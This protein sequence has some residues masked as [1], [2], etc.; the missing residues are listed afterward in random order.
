MVYT[1]RL[2]RGGRGRGDGGGNAF[3]TLLADLGI[4]QKNGKPFKPTT[5]GKIERLWQTLKRYLDA[6]H[7]DTIEQLQDVLDVFR[8]HYNNVRPHR[9]LNRATPATAYARIAKANPASTTGADTWRVRYDTVDA[10]G[11]ITLRHGGRFLHLGI[12]RAHAR[13]EIIALI[14]N[15][16]TTIITADNGDTLATFTLDPSHACQSKNG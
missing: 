2:A 3:E 16:D 7:I 14:H 6:C 5:Q 8:D 15:R 10:D 11:K 1:T 4:T 13:T 9:A 12:G